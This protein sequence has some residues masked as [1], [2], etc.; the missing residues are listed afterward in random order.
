M[1]LWQDCFTDDPTH[2]EKEFRR[3]FRM[4]KELY[5][6]IVTGVWEYDTYFKLKRDCVGLVGFSS[7][8]KC[9]AALRVLTYGALADTVDNYLRL[10]ESTCIKTMY[11]LRPEKDVTEIDVSSTKI[12]LDTSI[13][14][15]SFCG[16]REYI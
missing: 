12:C 8:Q 13:F 16:R 7:I 1:T 11:S 9:T 5:M 10:A 6:T 4:N 3:R 2:G 15:T 14:V